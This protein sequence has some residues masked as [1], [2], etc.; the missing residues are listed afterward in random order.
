VDWLQIIEQVGLPIAALVFLA[1][2]WVRYLW[3][4]ILERVAKGDAEKT[5][6]IA[7]RKEDQKRF[8]EHLATRDAAQAARDQMMANSLHEL[9]TSLTTRN[10]KLVQALDALS[11]NVKEQSQRHR[12]TD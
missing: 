2:L 7:E 4:F 12:R 5:A 9:S 1:W 8:M 6:I 3:P 10:D 11:A